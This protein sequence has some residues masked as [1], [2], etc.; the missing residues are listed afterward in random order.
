MWTKG[1]NHFCWRREINVLNAVC[2]P[3]LCKTS[4]VHAPEEW[5]AAALKECRGVWLLPEF[6]EMLLSH[7][8]AALLFRRVDYFVKLPSAAGEQPNT[9]MDVCFQ[10]RKFFAGKKEEIFPGLL[11]QPNF[12]LVSTEC[13]WWIHW[14]MSWHGSLSVAQVCFSQGVANKAL[15]VADMG[16]KFTLSDRWKVHPGSF[17]PSGIIT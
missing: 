13:Y 12:L 9:D 7:S 11:S 17:C 2:S 14:G 8:L 16:G 4:E 6:R 3:R 5:A 10:Q 15:S 1:S